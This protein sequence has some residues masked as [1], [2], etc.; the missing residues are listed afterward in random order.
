MCNL[1]CTMAVTA[2]SGAEGRDHEQTAWQGQEGLNVNNRGESIIT[3]LTKLSLHEYNYK[4]FVD[5]LGCM[6]DHTGAEVHA[7]E[8]EANTGT[9]QRRYS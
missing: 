9:G 1:L 2:C 7:R 4:S 8:T 6:T 5:I 3:Y